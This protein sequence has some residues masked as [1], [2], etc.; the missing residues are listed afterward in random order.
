LRLAEE[1][2]RFGATTSVEVV[3]AQAS[4]ADAERAEIAAVFAFHRSLAAL[5]ARTGGTLDR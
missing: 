5:E 4:L 2:F 3:D 1:R